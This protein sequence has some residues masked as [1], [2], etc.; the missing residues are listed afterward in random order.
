MLPLQYISLHNINRRFRVGTHL[1]TSFSNTLQRHV[2]ATNRFV[3]A[4]EFLWKSLSPQHNFVTT[5]SRK[6]SNQ[7]EFVGLVAA[8]KL[9]CREKDFRKNSPVHTKRF[10][11]ATCRRN[12]LLHSRR[13]STHGVICRRALLLQLVAECVPTERATLLLNSENRCQTPK[14]VKT[15]KISGM[16]IGYLPITIKFRNT[17]AN[18]KTTNYSLPL[19]SFRVSYIAPCWLISRNTV[20]GLWVS[21]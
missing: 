21:Q 1:A 11:V 15:W 4:G 14:T 16:I 6:K 10:V 19:L 8:T 13:T 20:Y 7:T 2:A 17:Q 5:T 9:C 12:V 18:V 3:C